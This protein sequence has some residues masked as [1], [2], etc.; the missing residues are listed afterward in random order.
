MRA[1]SMRASGAGVERA[2]SGTGSFPSSLLWKARSTSSRNAPR[3]VGAASSGTGGFYQGAA[4]CSF[5]AMSFILWFTGLSGAGK[6]TLARALE[7]ELAARGSRVEVLDG[8]EVREHIS[9]GLG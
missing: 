2:A 4:R 7:R 9:K 8:D 1:S 3:N 6:S 5:A